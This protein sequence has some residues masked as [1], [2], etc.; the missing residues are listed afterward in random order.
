MGHG[1]Y[2]VLLDLVS[3]VVCSPDVWMEQVV[4]F[5][6]YISKALFF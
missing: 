5:L 4:I 3:G 1:W 6:I 2:L